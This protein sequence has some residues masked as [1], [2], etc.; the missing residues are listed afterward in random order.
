M[1]A[2][3]IDLTERRARLAVRHRLTPA[4]RSD[5]VA[6]IADALVALH[7][8]DPVSVHLSAQARQRDPSVRSVEAALYDERRVVRHHAMRR[9]LWVMTPPV[10]R[11]AHGA[12][13]A[14]L[15]GAEERRLVQLLEAQGVAA[16]GSAWLESARR[17]TLAALERLG[18][19]TA[20]RLGEA[21]P[22]LTMRLQ[23]A[24]GKSY[25]ATVQ[26][27][28]RVLLQLG[29]EGAV[30]RTRPTGSWINGQYRWVTTGSWYDHPD[31]LSLTGADPAAAQAELADRY[32]QA[33]G[34]ATAEDL[35]W[36]AGWTVSTTKQALEACGA[37][38]VEVEAA[39]GGDRT[40]AYVAAGDDGPVTL[41]ED[42]DGGWV[43][44]LPGLDPT[45]MGWKQRDW[46]LDPAD[47]ATVFDRNG[48]GGPTVWADGRVV[49]GWVQRRSGE[50]A[51]RLLRRVPTRQEAAIAAAAR[52][53]E[54]RLGDVR[55]T[56]RFPAPLQTELR[57]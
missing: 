54:Q 4:L 53:L 3:L 27:H 10:A 12:A 13:T 24:A 48:N 19:A 39:A 52:D 6:A 8:S 47:A 34:P 18:P 7:S 55:F 30:L 36:W 41:G 33:F 56:V 21:V 17:E 32:L 40:I 9:T 28:T 51:W 14:S 57:R 31:G 38:L 44:L 42:A 11:V 49:G 50:V 35:R 45:T 43:A 46:Y 29:F 1:A 25:A 16:D 15:A 26:A 2:R 22:A 37:V 5:D 20:R 23:L